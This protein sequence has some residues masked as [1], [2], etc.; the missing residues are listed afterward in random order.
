MLIFNHILSSSYFKTEIFFTHRI[1]L[2]YFSLLSLF[3]ILFK[4]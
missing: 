2:V 1:K 4:T 3:L